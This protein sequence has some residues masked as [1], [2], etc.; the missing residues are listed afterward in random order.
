MIFRLKNPLHVERVKTFMMDYRSL[1][2]KRYSYS[3][4][5]KMTNS[6]VDTIGQGGFGNVYR[7]KLPD[8]G[9][10]VAVKVL[11]ESKAPVREDT[12]CGFRLTS[13]LSLLTFSISA[14]ETSGV[15]LLDGVRPF[16]LIN[17]VLDVIRE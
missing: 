16:L 11:K 4:I 1:T 3:D 6:F 5:K 7:G 2:P 14:R 9:R 10:L 17:I 12:L 15:H 13:T 8:D